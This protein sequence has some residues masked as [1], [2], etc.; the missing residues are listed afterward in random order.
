MDAPIVSSFF[1]ELSVLHEVRNPTV[2]KAVIK[3]KTV[4]FIRLG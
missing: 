1:W 3:V 4:V 2:A